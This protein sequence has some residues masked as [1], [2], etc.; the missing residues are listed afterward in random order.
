MRTGQ[1]VTLSPCAKTSFFEQE[2]LHCWREVVSKIDNLMS[3]ALY[4][5]DIGLLRVRGGINKA[6]LS[7]S[8]KKHP[9]VL[10]SRSRF[11]WLLIEKTHHNS[12]HQG[13]EH[14]TAH[15]TQTVLMIGLR[16]V[17]RN[18][19]KYCFI[20]RRW[21]TDN[22]RPKM[23]DLTDVRFLDVNKQYPFVNREVDMF[24]PFYIVDKRK[25]TQVYS[26]CLFIYL[27]VMTS[28]PI[29]FSWPS[30]DF[31]QDVNTL[32]SLWVTRAI[33]LL[34]PPRIDFRVPE[35]LQAENEYIKL[36]LAQQ[37]I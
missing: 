37:N 2:I 21:K 25:D 18:L 23:V 4:L 24:G 3:F 5:D 17:L 7:Y 33:T 27:C 22:V 26:L 32:T 14:V 34:K 15:L 8:A 10:H 31:H 28:Q 12:G 9:L 20:C 11:A 19:G 35:K 16:K 30:A 29:V 6:P 36:H 13:V 1:G